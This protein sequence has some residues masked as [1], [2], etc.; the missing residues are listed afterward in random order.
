MGGR[1]RAEQIMY[2]SELLPDPNEVDRYISLICIIHN[3]HGEEILD[4]MLGV[5]PN[6]SYNAYSNFALE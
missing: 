5:S 3:F 1:M 6:L 4:Y 2:E